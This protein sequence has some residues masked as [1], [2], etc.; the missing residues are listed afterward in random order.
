MSQVPTRCGRV[1]RGGS[2]R[3]WADEPPSL[4]ERYARGKAL[5]ATEMPVSD[6][7]KTLMHLVG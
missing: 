3:D 2:L 1:G 6:I 5:L 7:M 4:A